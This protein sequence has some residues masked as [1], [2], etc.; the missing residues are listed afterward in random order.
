MDLGLI[1]GIVALLNILKNKRLVYIHKIALVTKKYAF[2]IKDDFCVP[3]LHLYK[4][5]KLKSMRRL[6]HD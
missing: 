2:M 1:M 3:K 4:Y 5:R 6:L